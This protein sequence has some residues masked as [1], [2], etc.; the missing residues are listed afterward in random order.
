MST[1]REELLTRIRPLL[2]G[3]R[4][5]REVP[6]FGGTAI[7]L[8]E[9]MLVSVGRDGSLLVRIDPD[10]HEALLERAGARRAVMGKD[11]P[12]GPGWLAVEARGLQ[13]GDDL[14]AWLEVALAFHSR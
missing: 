3:G 1:D 7:M 6:M 13:S 14:I 9:T 4:P 2:P 12:M 11:R 10:D 5:V 8:E